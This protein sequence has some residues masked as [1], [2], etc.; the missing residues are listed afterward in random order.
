MDVMIIKNFKHLATNQDKKLALSIVEEGFV[1]A[2]PNSALERIVH[3]AFLQIGHKR[4]PLK[5]Y[6]HVYV[7]A[8]GKSAD[9]MTKIVNSRTKI[10]GGIVVIPAKMKPVIHEGKFTVMHASHPI[11]AKKSITA[12]RKISSFLKSMKPTDLIIFLISGGA[13]SLVSLPDGIS[14]KN[15]QLATSLLLKSGANIDEINCVRKHLSQVKG[16]RL[17]ESLSCRGISLVMSDV[18]GDDLSVIASGITYCDHSTF[19]DAKKILLKYHL[20]N[21]VPKSVLNRIILGTKGAI[22]ETPKKPKIENYVISTNKNCVDSMKSKAKKLGFATKT[23]CQLDGNVRN[24]AVKISK[25]FAARSNSC[26]VFG[27]ETTVT[28]KGSGYGGRNQ[29]LILN[30]LKKLKTNNE[31]IVV[32]SVG[33]DGIDGNTCVAGAIADS[34]MPTKPIDAYLKKNDSYYY[35]KKYGGSII[36]GPTHTNLMDIGLVLRK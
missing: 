31:K 27:G 15:K 12:A 28:V 3:P 34:T 2:L 13:S 35:F 18:I 22:P 7:V 20:T 5:K 16:G 6:P 19:S 1:S 36:T 29:E 11:P 23:I 26:L 33:T 9:L 4:I 14:L 8:I 24:A 30:L 32:V 10:D 17:V 21:L 25:Y